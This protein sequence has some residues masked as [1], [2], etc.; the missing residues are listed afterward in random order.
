MSRETFILSWHDYEAELPV[1]PDAKK[2]Y[3]LGV[4]ICRRPPVSR[5]E[6]VELSVIPWRVEPVG[7]RSEGF[8]KKCVSG[9]SP[10][11]GFLIL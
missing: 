6:F 3:P 5:M 8:L 1:S 4:F 10:D 11:D 7:M 9:I 2:Y